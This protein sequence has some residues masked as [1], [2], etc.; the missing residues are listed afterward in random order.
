M[1]KTDYATRIFRACPRYATQ[2]SGS[3]IAGCKR[4][5]IR[6]HQ[7]GLQEQSPASRYGKQT[8]P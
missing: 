2:T 7:R 3:Q 4:P 6:H 8:S 5:V 1:A